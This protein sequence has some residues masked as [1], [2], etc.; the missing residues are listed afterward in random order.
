[1]PQGTRC[2]AT[3]SGGRA[4]RPDIAAPCPGAS[5][6]DTR[7]D[8]GSMTEDGLHEMGEVPMMAV[9]LELVVATPG[10]GGVIVRPQ[11]IITAVFRRLDDHGRD[12]ALLRRGGC[13][14]FVFC[15]VQSG[16]KRLGFGLVVAQT[17]ASTVGCGYST[18]NSR[19]PS[20]RWPAPAVR[21]PARRCAER[22][23]ATRHSAR[24]GGRH[25][26]CH[27]ISKKNDQRVAFGPGAGCRRRK[28][29]PR[30]V[31][32]MP[33]CRSATAGGRLGAT[34]IPRRPGAPG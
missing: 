16:Q 15:E 4:G 34:R 3:T 21:G 32:C 1:M 5:H 12:Q 30:R 17:G 2:A 20:G 26:L 25:L 33:P 6:T 28:A 22:A 18:R 11:A 7:V 27:R 23:H 8:R 13:S 9:A 14:A 24:Q 29:P 31:A 19:S 10:W